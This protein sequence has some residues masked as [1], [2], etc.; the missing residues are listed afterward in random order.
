MMGALLLIGLGILFVITVVGTGTV[1]APPKIDWQ[2]LYE[3]A[4][5][6]RGTKL[7]GERI[8]RVQM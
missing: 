1:D 2:E 4:K 3:K 7:K 5:R 8:P 6:Q